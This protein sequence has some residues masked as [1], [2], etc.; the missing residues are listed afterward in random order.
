VTVEMTLW[1]RTPNGVWSARGSRTAR[2]RPQDLEH[3][4]GKDL[5]DDPQIATVFKVVEAIGLGSIDPELKR[6]SLNIGAATRLALA[7]ARKAAN[8]DLARFA[9]RVQEPAR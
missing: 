1:V 2:V 3:D 6:R 8:E 5:A 7:Q 9:L 4:A